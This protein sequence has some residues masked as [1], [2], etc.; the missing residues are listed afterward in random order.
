MH[1]KKMTKKKYNRTASKNNFSKETLTKMW[2]ESKED[3]ASALMA[4]NFD[5]D[6]ALK[7]Y[8]KGYLERKKNEISK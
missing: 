7:E 6:Q 2:N 1:V 5:I 8:K 3:R 4:E